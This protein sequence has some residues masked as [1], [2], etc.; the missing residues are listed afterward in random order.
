MIAARCPGILRD[1]QDE[2]ELRHSD[3]GTLSIAMLSIG[4]AGALSV[5][6]VCSAWAQ[7][8]GAASPPLVI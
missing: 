3:P 2:P 8:K 5:T 6:M 4:G 1:T 7:K